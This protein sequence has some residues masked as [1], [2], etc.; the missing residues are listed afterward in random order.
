VCDE[1]VA[2]QMWSVQRIP[3]ICCWHLISVTRNARLPTVKSC[4][5]SADELGGL[6]RPEMAV[7]Q[8]SDVLNVIG[9]I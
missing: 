8:I 4:I 5:M 1:T 2:L 3:N 9:E 7:V 6:H